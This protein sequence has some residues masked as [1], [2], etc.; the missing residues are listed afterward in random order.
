MVQK[1]VSILM[2]PVL[3][4]YTLLPAAMGAR[5]DQTFQ[6]S[7]LK[8]LHSLSDY[9]NY[10][11][12][13]GAPS[14]DTAAFIRNL[15]PADMARK[16][17]HG[18]V[19]NR[20]EEAYLDV[21]LEET[22]SDFCTYLA[23]NTGFD[24][25]RLLTHVPNMNG[26]AEFGAEVLHVDTTAFR[27]RMYEMR[28]EANHNGEEF[29][30]NLLWLVGAYFSVIQKA[31]IVA[32][33]APEV[34]DDVVKVQVTVSYYDGY[35]EVMYPNIYINKRTGESFG[36]RDDGLMSFGFNCDI[37]DM[38]V[39]ATVNAWQ[40]QYGFMLLYDILANSSPLFNY[41]TR[42]LKFD[43]N[44]KEWMIQIWKGNYALITNGGEV[45]V[46]NREP[47]SRGTYY[48]AA[49]D[50]E[51]MP[52]KMQVWHGDDLLLEIGE[53]EHWWMNGFK[54][55]KVIYQPKDLTLKFYMK[56][57]N[58]EMLNAFADSIDKEGTGDITYTIDGLTIYVT[59]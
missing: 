53:M 54:M 13:H 57:P 19:L 36:K 3:F 21:Q 48:D 58:E 35:K 20:A 28:D 47:G 49:S 51:M 42:R 24:L 7:D 8:N 16:I 26:L 18:Q 10:V 55:T 32:V 33:P 56:M 15:T 41:Q 2:V 43:Y 11:Q 52:M 22:L 14:F 40:R 31:D 34:G 4:L 30:A 38:V 39:Y 23:D 17:L 9:I 1:I 45:G 25:E 44:G 12:E 37:T 46:Y 59:F 5:N 27:K 29:K 6:I 50:D